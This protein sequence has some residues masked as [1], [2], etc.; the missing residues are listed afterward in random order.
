MLEKVN[1]VPDESD[2]YLTWTVSSI[3]MDQPLY[4]YLGDQLTPLF[5]AHSHPQEAN[6]S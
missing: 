6:E 5:F 3:H 2:I 4:Q 1:L